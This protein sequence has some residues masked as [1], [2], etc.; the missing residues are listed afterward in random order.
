[1]KKISFAIL[2]ALLLTL[3]SGCLKDEAFVDNKY[4]INHPE[5]SPVG[6]GFPQTT[7][8]INVTS[9]ENVATPQV[10]QIALVN[11]LSDQPMPEDVQVTLVNNPT[12][13]SSYNTAN[14]ASVIAMPAGSFN[15]ASMTVTIPAGK[16]TATVMLTIPNAKNQLDITKTYGFGFTIS[17]ATGGAVVA[18]NY[19]NILVGISIKNQWDG[20][21]KI[22]GYHVRGG[23]ATLTGPT[24][25]FERSF[26]TSGATSVTWNGSVPWGFQASQLPAGYE[27][28]IRVNE[29]TNKVTITSSNGLASQ[30]NTYDNRWDPAKKTFYIKWMY[31]AGAE[32]SFIDTIVFNRPRP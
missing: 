21:Y 2:S 13:V 20:I 31:A 22:N 32:R 19:K 11:L 30:V 4:G 24:G 14:S 23:D 1:M 3:G 10:L 27:P 25:E 5:N 8:K 17:S 29:A 18:S 15:I 28:I 12:L 16:T 7:N 26:S 9:I 6:V